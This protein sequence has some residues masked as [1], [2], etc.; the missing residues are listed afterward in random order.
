[1]TCDGK[2][3]I[4]DIEP[5]YS[6]RPFG[7]VAVICRR[8]TN[9]IYHELTIPSDRAIAVCVS[10]RNGTPVQILLNILHTLLYTPV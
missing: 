3:S 5:D 8:N 4:T 10:D 1:M 6:G 7:G 2:V 9:L